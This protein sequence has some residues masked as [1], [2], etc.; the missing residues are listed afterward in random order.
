VKLY[1]YIYIYIYTSVASGNRDDFVY[2][3][4]FEKY[5]FSVS[6]GATRRPDRSQIAPRIYV[7]VTGKF[8]TGMTL[9]LFSAFFCHSRHTL[10]RFFFW[11]HSDSE[12]K[13]K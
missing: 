6:R 11:L 1:T 9:I 10:S 12:F 13:G 8:V 7:K 3:S 2:S 5:R 4:S